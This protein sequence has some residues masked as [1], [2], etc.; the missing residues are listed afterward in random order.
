MISATGNQKRE[1]TRN[2]FSLIEIVLVLGLMAIASSVIVVNFASMADHGSTQSTEELLKAAIREARFIAAQGRAISSLRFDK[3]SGKLLIETASGSGPTYDL[4]EEYGKNGRNHIRFFLIP[5]ARGLER[6]TTA[7][8]V[9][10]PSQR[11][12]FA[13]DRSS[14][15]FVVEIEGEASTPQRLIFDPFSNLLVTPKS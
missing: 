14:S 11:I 10:N 9:K 4:S 7:K 15:P 3:N 5:P 13:P 8:D 2:G 1:R 6:M 12:K